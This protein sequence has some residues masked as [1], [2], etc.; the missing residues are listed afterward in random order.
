MHIPPLDRRAVV[1]AG[2]LTLAIVAIAATPQLLGSRVGAALDAVGE[3]GRGW[4]W[5]A[6]LAFLVSLVGAAGAW[7]S[8]VRLCGSTVGFVDANARYGV[9][10][11][12]N[13]FIPARAGDAVRIALFARTLDH[14]DRLWTT[15]GAVAAV[16]AA[17]ATA[18]G[19]LVVCAAAMDALPLWPLLVVCALVGVTVVVAR[20]VRDGRARTHVAHVLD[21]FRELGRSPKS[22]LRILAWVL[23][24]T[25][26]RVGA[27]AAVAAALGVRAPL[28]AAIIIV[29]ALELASLFPLTPGNL[30]VTSG[31]IAVTLKAHGIAVTQALSAGIAFHAVETAVSVVFGLLSL[32]LVAGASLHGARRWVLVGAAASACLVVAGVFG[33]TVIAALV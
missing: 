13:T 11:L 4:L 14:P 17:R 10:S 29:P 25:A 21:A 33:A 27:A 32:L 12:A 30:G 7:R 20:R 3:A 2:L 9:G 18:L 15:G 6:A 23:L 22:G 19:V 31:A 26:G 5:I 24:T 16:G 8:A 28:A 1:G